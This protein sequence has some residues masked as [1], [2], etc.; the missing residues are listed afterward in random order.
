LENV[1]KGK[2]QENQAVGGKIILEWVLK[3]D[4]VR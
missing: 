1:K 3:E 4:G 2:C